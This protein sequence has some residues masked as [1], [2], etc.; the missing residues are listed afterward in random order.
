MKIGV[1]SD[2]HSNYYAFK[3]CVDYMEQAGI[4]EFLL[5]GDF[6]SDTSF[7]EKTMELLYDLMDRYKVHILKGNR[8]EYLLEQRA[9]QMGIKDGIKWLPNSASGSLLFTYER[10]TRKDWE[11]FEKLPM[12]FKYECEDFPAITCCHGSPDNLR[13]L[14]YLNGENTKKWLE[15]IET[16]YL[17]AAHTHFPAQME[18]NDKHYFNTGCVGIAISDA[19][20][21]QCMILHGKNDDGKKK[22]IPEFLKIPYDTK[23]I[24]EDIFKSGLHDMAPWF[25]N[26]NIQV[27]LTG[28]DHSAEMVAM[29]ID[30]QAKET[31]KEVTWPL[32]EEKYFEQAAAALG[33]PDYKD[34]QSVCTHKI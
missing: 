1:I 22:W 20:Y 4:S 16:D 12:T 27:L 5:L 23:P 21:A 13:E 11:L 28:V 24:I 10:L 33:V 18:Y 17:L 15:K 32:I 9:V 31:K 34:Y 14:L 30:L 2:I 7:P 3:A 8:E 19:G 25:I 29:A 6:V 26:S